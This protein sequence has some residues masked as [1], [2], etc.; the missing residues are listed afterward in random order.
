MPRKEANT[1]TRN[2]DLSGRP[3]ISAAQRKRLDNLA[4]MDDSQID[5]S[6][7]PAKPGGWVRAAQ[8]PRGKTQI[9]LRI[10]ADVLEFFRDTGSG[11]QTM[12]NAVLREYVEA[13]KSHEK[14]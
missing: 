3:R 2:I 13:F 5:Y 10:D 8:M 1:V 4:Q 7:A 14:R 6:D 12:I 9:T 11:Y